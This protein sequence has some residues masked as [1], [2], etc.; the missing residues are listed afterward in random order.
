VLLSQNMNTLHNDVN[1][2]VLTS[3]YPWIGN[4]QDAVFVRQQI[5]KLESN[6]IRCRLL[7]FRYSPRGVPAG[8]WRI[9]Y[10]RRLETAD[11]E[12]GFP[13]HD[14]F[15]SRSLSRAE[16]VIPRVARGLFE[17]I[18][19]TPALLDTD[20]VYA[21]WLWPAGAAALELRSCFGW[22]VAAIAR[23]SEMHYWQQM[24]PHCRPYVQKV[25]REA[26]RVLTNCG[27][28]RNEACKLVSDLKRPIEVV[29]NGCDAQFFSPTNDRAQAKQ[30][31]GVDPR[32]KLMLFCGSVI[33]RKGIRNLTQAWERFC[34]R[35]SEWRLVAVGRLVESELV[36][37]LKR[38]AR[39]IVVGPVDRDAVL[40]YM[41]AA[42][43]YVQPSIYEG[44]ANATM[45]AMAT[46][47]PVIT[48]DTGGQCELIEDGFNGI[49]IPIQDCHALF[50]AF[51]AI[52]DNPGRAIQ[53]GAR[54]RET[55]ITRFSQQVQITKLTSVL[56]S[57]A[58]GHGR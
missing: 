19:R 51:V 24:N 22:P 26:D 56:K 42:D 40:A 17:Y 37:L 35:T 43:A 33:E 11:T 47:L 38:T 25:I 8:L 41:Q 34:G 14:V 28:L 50:Q 5:R 46:G 6:G 48:T 31:L 27:G 52:S 13:V 55:I 44:L 54:A 12:A 36:H 9:R 32:T 29:Y 20:V 1:L 10:L 23:G 53:M 15:V 39:T 30:K 49:L 3:I 18:R 2:L 21:H 57:I 58:S 4:P 45:E 7:T 16:D